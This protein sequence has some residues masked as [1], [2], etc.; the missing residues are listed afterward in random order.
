MARRDKRVQKIIDRPSHASF[1][2][3]WRVL[4][5]YGWEHASTKGSHA[6]F[7]KAGHGSITIPIHNDKVERVYLDK[8]CVQ[9]GLDEEIEAN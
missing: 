3:V 1:G 5:M 6:R 4:E 2:D 7:R 8:I 9:L